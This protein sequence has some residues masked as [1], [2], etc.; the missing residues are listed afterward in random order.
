MT[1]IANMTPPI[2]RGTIIGKQTGGPP[3]TEAE[4]FWK[5]EAC[6][7]YFDMRDL[8]AV[9]DHEEP[10]P[11]RG[12]RS[13]AVASLDHQRG[14]VIRRRDGRGTMSLTSSRVTTRPR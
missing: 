7:G 13:G 4:H 6:G 12:V 10:L 2:P 11:H 3:L 5:C 9:F 1:K 8:G 14:V